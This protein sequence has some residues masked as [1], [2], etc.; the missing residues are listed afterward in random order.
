M[1][2]LRER[3]EE[4]V[5]WR[6]AITWA[7]VGWGLWAAQTDPVLATLLMLVGVFGFQAWL[8]G[9]SWPGALRI[10]A[11]MTMVIVPIA[12]VAAYPLEAL[13]LVVLLVKAG[14]GILTTTD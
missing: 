12:L 11:G 5:K 10:G 8:S 6:T 2:T 9:Y 7:I 3:A 13:A 1:R 4:P 14:I